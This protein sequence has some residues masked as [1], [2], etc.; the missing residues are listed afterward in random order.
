MSFNYDLN[1][2]DVTIMQA[3]Y[4]AGAENFAVGMTITE[5]IDELKELGMVKTRLTIYRR[6]QRLVETEY[7][8]KGILEDHADTYYVTPKSIKLLKAFEELC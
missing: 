3:L 1:R 2:T 7:L 8:A 5:L 6:M 4:S